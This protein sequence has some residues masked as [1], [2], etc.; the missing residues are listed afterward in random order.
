MSNFLS[1]ASSGIGGLAS[2]MLARQFRKIDGAV[3]DLSNP[4]G[5]VAIKRGDSIFSMVKIDVPADGDTPA[6][7]EIIVQENPI[8]SFGITIPAYAIAKPLAQVEVGDMIVKGNNELAWVTKVNGASVSTIDSRGQNTRYSPST[9][10]LLGQTGQNVM[11]VTSL[12]GLFGGDA[13][14]VSGFQGM[15]LPLL[16]SGED[17]GSGLDDILPFMLLSQAGGL[18][19][20]A[21]GATGGGLFDMS[22]PM[23]LFILPKLL[24][25]GAGGDI[26]PTMLLLMSGGL[27]GGAAGGNNMMQ[28]L[29]MSKVL[30]G[31]S[32]F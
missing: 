12:M 4:N 10:P 24:G 18:G 5:G 30:G 1:N 20:A 13:G 3:W 16:L 31:K 19:G 32:P 7:T 25:K 6:T 27:G 23:S 11:V 26:D 2:S 15:L 9:V 29:L 21:A 8:G 17:L 22:N 28:M 14:K